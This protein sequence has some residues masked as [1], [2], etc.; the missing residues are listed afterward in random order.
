MEGIGYWFIVGI[1]VVV[2]LIVLFIIYSFFQ[3]SKSAKNLNK[4]AE[5]VISSETVLSDTFPKASNLNA[6][7][8]SDSKKNEKIEFLKNKMNMI[9]EAST[10]TQ[11]DEKFWVGPF[12]SPKFQSFYKWDRIL[13]INEYDAFPK[14]E[15]IPKDI[16]HL[17]IKTDDHGSGINDKILEQAYEFLEPEGRVLVCCMAG[18]NRS[19]AM[20]IMYL[21]KKY[22][23]DFNLAFQYV[24][25]R[26]RIAMVSTALASKIEKFCN[27]TPST[28]NFIRSSLFSTV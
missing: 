4:T 19:V 16:P 15:W 7:S 5:V 17:H 13:T 12:D 24:Q 10:V 28:N 21:M 9:Q 2:A 22:S 18:R 14:K 26:R 25:K 1:V 20:I 11:V 27:Q 6:S 8:K 3:R 23:I